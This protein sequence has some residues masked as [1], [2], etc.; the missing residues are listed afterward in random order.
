MLYLLLFG[1]RKGL[2]HSFLCKSLHVVRHQHYSGCYPWSGIFIQFICQ[3]DDRHA[4][5]ADS[6]LCR[7][8]ST[9]PKALLS[10]SIF[11]K[12]IDPVYD[13]SPPYI[14]G[15]EYFGRPEMATNANMFADAFANFGYIGFLI[16]TVILAAIL[17]LYDSLTQNEK[18]QGVGIILFVVPA[19]CLADTALTTTFVTG[20]MVFT[21]VI[22]YLMLGSDSQKEITDEV[23][24]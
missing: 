1:R 17:W 14:I 12:F 20:G 11:E 5:V 24:L 19:W 23:I 8:L 22:M 10:Y 6:L 3:K 16:Y 9:H 15:T 13:K 21:F 18:W 2:L 7:L 4:G